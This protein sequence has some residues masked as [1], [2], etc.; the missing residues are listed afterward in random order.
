MPYFAATIMAMRSTILGAPQGRLNA[1][2]GGFPHTTYEFAV[3]GLQATVDSWLERNDTPP[4]VLDAG[5]GHQMYVRLPT[6]AHMVGVD[7]DAE[8][9]ARNVTLDEKILGDIETYP[10]PSGSFDIVICYDVLEHLARPQLALENLGRAVAPGGLLVLGGPNL[11]SLKGL[12]TR[13][14]PHWL[15]RAYYRRTS[16]VPFRTYLKYAATPAKIDQW[17]STAALA[18]RYAVVYENAQQIAARAKIR[19]TGR[20]WSALRRGV[21]AVT[22]GFIDLAATDFTMVLSKTE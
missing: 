3:T 19:L 12:I 5:C 11:L 4:R 22:L 15:H 20:L 10:F 1:V 8:Q 14:T 9:L 17:A 18:A 6:E 16:Y 2:V 7:L 21:H 13:L